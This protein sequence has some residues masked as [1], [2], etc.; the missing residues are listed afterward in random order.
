LTIPN[1]VSYADVAAEYAKQ[2]GKNLGFYPA[3]LHDIATAV[4]GVVSSTIK[5]AFEP[6]EK[7]SMEISCERIPVGLRIAVKD[8]GLPVYAT[9]IFNKD[10]HPVTEPT[11]GS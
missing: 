4:R 7:A 9:E 5:D 8:M 1:E 3:D 2:V 10:A 11:P 6:S